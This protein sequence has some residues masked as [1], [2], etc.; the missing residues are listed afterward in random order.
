MTRINNSHLK[1]HGLT[2]CQ[3]IEQYP[4]APLEHPDTR[5]LYGSQSATTREKIKNTANVRKQQ[6]IEKYMLKPKHCKQCNT[7]IPYIKHTQTE[8]CSHS[9]AASHTNQSR[10]L[11]EETKEKIRVK[12]APLL[13]EY[14]RS[15]KLANIP[16][17]KVYFKNCVECD[18]IFTSTT[19]QKQT[20]SNVCRSVWC[21]KH[22]FRQ[23]KTRGK[24]GYFNG[25]WCASSWE[26][27]FVA[28]HTYLNSGIKRFDSSIPYVLNNKQKRYFPD[29]EINKELYEV[30]GWYDDTVDIK[31]QAAREAGYVIH[32]I[33]RN[34]IKPIIKQVKE[35]YDIKNIL[36]LYNVVI[37]ANEEQ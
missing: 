6:R 19:R 12:T 23:N 18:K 27:A 35:W 37:G 34:D 22:N 15:R 28:Y 11:S 30:K 3:F 9:C 4:N 21:S 36:A 10:S 31:L 25:V 24:C 33:T 17:T 7:I 29:F 1:S 32:I 26:L 13:R 14:A 5:K 20:C 16:F 2:H 8:Y